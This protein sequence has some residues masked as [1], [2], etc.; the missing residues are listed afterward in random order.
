MPEID[1]PIAILAGGSGRR[2]GSAK[3]TCKCML[4]LGGTPLLEH[5]LL[6]LKTQSPLLVLNTN[7]APELFSSYQLTI[8]P[9]LP[10]R[11]LGPLG[12]LWSVWKHF[13]SIGQTPEYLMSVA[14]DT[15]FLP[16]DLLATL[17]QSIKPEHDVLFCQS[18]DREHFIN[19][20]WANSSFEQLDTFLH[21]GGRSVGQFIRSIRH[22]KKIFST[23]NIDPFFNINTPEQL[24]LAQRQL[25]S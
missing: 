18:Q 6:R 17:A 20:L 13:Q 9:D 2:M 12:G 14:G 3:G 7:D 1:T 15:P 21:E 4:E 8:V 24:T 10:P 5:I 23:N 22:E 25:E 11:D 16:Q 19:A